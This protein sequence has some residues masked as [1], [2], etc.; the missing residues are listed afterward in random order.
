MNERRPDQIDKMVYSETLRVRQLYYSACERLRQKPRQLSPV[1][2]MQRSVSYAHDQR[3]GS[4]EVKHTENGIE[5]I[6]RLDPDI[7]PSMALTYPQF[8]DPKGLHNA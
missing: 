6:G 1:V 2:L 8:L 3:L 4:V 5:I 7:D